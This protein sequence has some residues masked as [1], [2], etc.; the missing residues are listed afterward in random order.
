LNLTRGWLILKI[1]PG[2]RIASLGLTEPSEILDLLLQFEQLELPSNAQSLGLF[3]LLPDPVPVPG[4]AARRS[5][6]VLASVWL[7]RG[8]RA[9]TPSTLLRSKVSG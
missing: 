9:N 1:P 6:C 7:R 2:S 3:K 5:A 8:L 4:L